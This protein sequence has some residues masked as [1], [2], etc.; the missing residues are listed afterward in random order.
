VTQAVAVDITQKHAT[1]ASP[2]GRQGALFRKYVLVF[3][4]LITGTLLTSSLTESYVAYQ[5]IRAAL[6]GLQRR[7]ATAAAD[8]IERFIS[9]I[10]GQITWAMVTPWAA[11]TQAE[12]ER[13][14]AFLSLLRLAPAVTEVS[15]VDS[16]GREQ[17]R[18]S[19][20]AMDAVGSQE[21]RSKEV[22]FRETRTNNVYRSPV[23][24]R[25]EYEPYIT[26]A[27][28]DPGPDGGVTVADVNLTLIWDVVSRIK[29]GKSGH[30]YV[31]DSDGYLIAHPD[32]SEVLK[33]PKLD[34]LSRPEVRE[35]LS[36]GSKPAD[37]LREPMDARRVDGRP[38][39]VSYAPVRL[40][41]A[42]DRQT[43]SILVEQPLEEALEPLY[44]SLVPFA[45]LLLVG[46]ALSVLVSLALARRMIIPIHALQAGVDRIS[47]GQ[48]GYRIELKTGDELEALAGQFNEMTAKLQHSYQTLEDE[49]EGRTRELA[50]AVQELQAL[51]EVSQTVSSTPDLQ[52][53]LGSVV[54]HAVRLSAADAGVIFEFD[55]STAEFQLRGTHMLD[56]TVS[57]LLRTAPLRLGEGAVG[58][59]GQ[60]RVPVQIHDIRQEGAYSGRMREA[61][62]EAGLRSL[63]AVP[64]LL[65]SRVVGGLVV[66]RTTPGE[67]HRQVVELLQTFTGHSALAIHNARLFE[68]IRS[69]S[70]ELEIANKHKSEFLRRMSHELRTPLQAIIGFTTVIID[71]AFD[72]HPEEIRQEK[73]RDRLMRVVTN[74]QALL[75]LINDLLDLAKMEPGPPALS[76]SDYSLRDVVNTVAGSLESL[77][78]SKNLILRVVLPPDLPPGRGDE[79]QI[80]EVLSN[81]LGNAIKFTDAGEV[82]VDVRASEDEFS[83]SVSDT[84][85][86]IALADQPRVFEPFWQSDATNTREKGGTGLGLAIAKG[87]VEAHGGSIGVK[88]T[89]GNGSTFC[90][91]LPIRVDSRVGTA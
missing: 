85:P 55:E 82:V 7:E 91:V 26:L 11:G 29:I 20:V 27:F 75:A 21:D 71:G 86:G 14:Y 35:A 3:V 39:L 1:R 70:R 84:G 36:G 72:D 56:A 68:E 89:P 28:A 62:A 78:T 50:R 79:R 25:D 77:A 24:F 57:D 32:I 2:R 52:Q 31:V 74:S 17:L 5:E 42:D 9:Q 90:F 66:A 4:I 6:G 43:W 47:K 53:V 13:R 23:G 61:L 83:V 63:L 60:T 73:I 33:K 46:L 41:R 40:S 19:R 10:E 15:Y 51:A 30:A 58:Q 48:L 54:A 45:A 80:A 37:E 16:R 44:S 87:I 69:K 18:V 59:A 81:L 12:Q 64:L 22:W 49:V 65:E 76:V 88:S 38:V 8:S 67:F 34:L